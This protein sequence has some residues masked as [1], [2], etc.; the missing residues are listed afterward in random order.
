MKGMDRRPHVQGDGCGIAVE[1]TEEV[2][3]DAAG[4]AIQRVVWDQLGIGTYLD[5]ELAEVGGRY[6]P[7]LYAEQWTTLLAYGGGCMDHL[8]LLE[9][10]GVG[11][12]MGWLRVVD[13]TSFGR[14]LRR[15]GQKG[16]EVVDALVR[17]VVAAR[18][19]AEGKVPR[20][21]VLKLDSTVSVRYGVKQAGAEVG[22]NP[23]KHGRTSHHPL[24]A[25][26]DTGDVLGVRWRPGKAHTAAGAEEW[27]EELVAWLRAQGVERILVRLDKGF[28]RKAM[29]EKLTELRVDFVLKMG[30]LKPLQVF[31][32]PFVK[33]PRLAD[34]E[35]STAERWGVRMLGLRWLERGSEGELEL[36]KVVVRHQ[37][38]ILSNL[39]IDPV[40][41]WD[42]YN[43]GALVEQRIEELSQLGVGRTAVDDL[44]GNALLWNLGVLAYQLFH[45]A[46]TQAIRTQ[47]QVKTVRTLILRAPGK[48]VRHARRL[49]LK[50][51][52]NDPMTPRL[53]DALQRLRSSEATPVTAM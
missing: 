28:F 42:M 30:E 15:A 33:E 52:R 53:L 34:V 41:A 2:L 37:A 31:K 6:R 24:L 45:Y 1:T 29:I 3:T 51:T 27:L 43:Q 25:F 9:S 22:Y 46:R 21:V 23:K 47:E 8:P 36:G 18:W 20:V 7:S 4:L 26:L 5:R 35:V 19:K 50:L 13:P 38:T 48:L 39:D 40:T 11:V 12:L 16:S 10:R 14:F 49:R 44:G 17:K 32:G